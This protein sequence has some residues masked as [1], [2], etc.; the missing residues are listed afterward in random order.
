MFYA[1][2]ESD[3]RV[4][5]TPGETR[6]VC[7]LC[8]A[9]VIPKC[10]AIKIHHWAHVRAECDSW[11]EPESAWHLGWKSRFPAHQVEVCFGPH[12]ADVATDLRVIEL[13]HSAISPA[14]IAAREEFYGAARPRGM[15]WLLDA[16][17]IYDRMTLEQKKDFVKFRWPRC[18]ARWF[19]ATA[20]ICLD[21]GGGVLVIKKWSA[22]KS[23]MYGWGYL[24]TPETFVES[25]GG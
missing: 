6:A 7:P 9:P 15:V 8:R 19:G 14:D 12:R 25:F 1:Q 10:G 21:F 20:P 18:P 11:S 16:T 2:I 3:P 13:Q 17:E 4:R 23:S 5:P 22:F 24:A